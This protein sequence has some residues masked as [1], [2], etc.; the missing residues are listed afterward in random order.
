[1]VLNRAV[2]DGILPANP[3]NQLKR[4]ER[5]KKQESSREYLTLDEVKQLVKTECVKPVV[6]QAFL[7]SCF[8]GLCF[9]DV[10]ALKWGD[11]QTDN[12][13]KRLIRYTQKKTGKEEHLQ[14]S[15]EALKFLPEQGTAK[16]TDTVFILSN[17]GYTNNAMKSWILASGI[18]KRVTFHV[19]RHT[20]IFVT[21]CIP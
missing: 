13:G 8:S 20:N 16:D 2:T 17:N 21:H 14:V 19:A 10:K 18:K 4:Q 12:E 15:G 3:L 9:S 1:M 6:K 11:F 7:F 5:P